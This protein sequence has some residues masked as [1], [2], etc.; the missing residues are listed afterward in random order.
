MLLT[1]I[2]KVYNFD[3][4]TFLNGVFGLTEGPVG[5]RVASQVLADGTEFVH[6][7]NLSIHN[8]AEHDVSLT[9][10]DAYF[11][12]NYSIDPT[13]VQGLINFSMDGKVLSARDMVRYRQAREADSKL[14]NPDCTFGIKEQVLAH[15]EMAG[16]LQTMGR[17]W[18]LPIHHA[19]SFFLHE[20]I[21]SDF[22]PNPTLI[23]DK[24]VV[25]HVAYLTA[26]WEWERMQNPEKP[27][28]N[29]PIETRQFDL[30]SV[31]SAE[32]DKHVVPANASNTDPRVPEEW[33]G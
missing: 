24:D 1:A 20:R 12:D 17:N 9:R 19:E 29:L 18:Q 31:P 13:L 23:T 21:P 3:A 8:K 22:I 30:V 25:G 16:G 14:R 2:E 15:V 33:H 32:I 4:N 26:L 27:S 10:Q 7:N 5:V 6:L 11:G 28:Y